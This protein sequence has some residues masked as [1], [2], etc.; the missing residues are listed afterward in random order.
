M[1]EISDLIET[2]TAEVMSEIKVLMSSTVKRLKNK[3]DIAAVQQITIDLT[4][5]TVKL[6]LPGTDDTERAALLRA[7]DSYKNALA[8]YKGITAIAA[9][10]L[11]LRAIG[12]AVGIVAVAA[13]KAL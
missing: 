8:C 12:T 11:S 3:G 10:E 4:R 9:R 7:I 6:A 2:I 13:M 5:A 1:S